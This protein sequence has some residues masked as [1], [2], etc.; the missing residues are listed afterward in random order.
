MAFTME[1]DQFISGERFQGLADIS[2]IPS[3]SEVGESDFYFVKDQQKNN[4][5]NAFYYNEGIDTIPDY[6][7]NAKIIFVNTW[8]FDKFFKY[9]F[10][11]LTGKY[12]FISH[13][14]DISFD[15]RF[16]RYLNTEKV[17][18]WFSQN[19]EIIHDKLFSLPIGIA[20]QQYEHGDLPLLKHLC[21]QDIKKDNLVY[22]NFNCST[23][24]SERIFIDHITT[25]NGIL[26][27]SNVQQKDYFYNLARS[28][29]A[30]SPPGNG[31]D[32][33]RVW[34]CL[35]LNTVPIVK[36]SNTFNQFTDLPILFIDDWNTIN[37][38]WL[39]VRIELM[40]K[41][42]SQ[43]IIRE[44]LSMSYWKNKIN[45]FRQ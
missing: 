9:I 33:H 16:E 13:N 26:M 32:C 22:K 15:S 1:L 36:S 19:T 40:Q 34:E 30:V 25:A 20:N 41:S 18:A 37:K 35:Y 4:N 23:N 24:S 38:H 10:P 27:H 42:L 11:L 12:I 3:G 21:E 43:S 28:I 7:Q 6:V 17:I 45:K 5:Y 2:I 39:Q 44:K 29:F 31:P 8:T 14:S